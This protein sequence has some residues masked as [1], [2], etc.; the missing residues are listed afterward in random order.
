MIKTTYTITL[1]NVTD[2]EKLEATL[3]QFLQIY[4]VNI[5]VQWEGNDTI[6]DIDRLTNLETQ[7]RALARMY[8]EGMQVHRETLKAHKMEIAQIREA[9]IDKFNEFD[10]RI[11]DCK[12]RF[13]KHTAIGNLMHNEVQ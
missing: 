4:G 10:E 11:D 12:S 7:Q 6:D 8:A 5:R 2:P 1:D 13:E 9:L 3:K